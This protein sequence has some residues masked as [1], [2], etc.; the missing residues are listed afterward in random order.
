MRNILLKI[1]YE[2]TNFAGWQ[3]QADDIR[4]VQGEVEKALS[5]ACH[6]DCKIEG[7]SR[8]DAGVHANALC[9]SLIL[10][11]EGIP[12]DK[13]PRATNDI[14][15]FDKLEG[16]GDVKILS[17]TEM[18]EGFHARHSAKGKRYIY[19]IYNCENKSP[20]RRTQFYQVGKML[21]VERMRKAC[22]YIKGT[23]D[24]KCFET[25]SNSPRENTVR[26]IYKLDVLRNAVSDNAWSISVVVEGDGF[27]YNMVRIIVGTLVEVGL[28]KMEPEEL[29]AIIESKDRGNAGHTAPPQGLYLDE[30]FYEAME[31]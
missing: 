30:V 21:D 17:A 10:P 13:I 15:A 11:D 7:S 16:I 6:Y 22:E 12:T 19:R 24:F 25:S 28:G 31:K 14:L 29:K 3:R 1:Q 20:F 5:E 26:T 27:L 2:G 9:A 8:T 4:T 23:H 18:P